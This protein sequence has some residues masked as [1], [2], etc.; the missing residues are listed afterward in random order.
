VRARRGNYRKFGS[1][2]ILPDGRVRFSAWTLQGLPALDFT[3]I[4]DGAADPNY[5]ISAH[6]RGRSILHVYLTRH[7]VESTCFPFDLSSADLRQAVAVL[8]DAGN[9]LER[10]IIPALESTQR[11]L[12]GMKSN[13]NPELLAAIPEVLRSAR[14][15]PVAPQWKKRLR[16]LERWER[17]NAASLIEVGDPAEGD[18]TAPKP[19]K[20]ARRKPGKTP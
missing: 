20:P 3:A 18:T 8:R 2:R 9:G 4:H 15:L 11:T 12:G 1:L 17:E 5:V 10:W 6:W 13:P 14:A 7:R 19:R 16:F